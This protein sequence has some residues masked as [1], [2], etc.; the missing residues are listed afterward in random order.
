M[1]EVMLM[2]PSHLAIIPDGNRRWAKLHRKSL[3][4][5]YKAGIQR[6]SDAIAWCK[7]FN[8]RMLTMWGFS[9][10]NFNRDSREVRSLLALFESKLREALRSDEFHRNKIRVR[11]IGRV[12]SFPEKIQSGFRE[13][14]RATREYREYNLNILLGYGGQRE[15]VDAC[16]AIIRDY[17][18]GAITSVDETVFPNYLYT[19]GLPD[20]DLIIRTSGEQ[21]LS[22]LMPWQSAYS[23]LYFSEK[24]WPDFEKKDMALA[25]KEFETR[26]RRFGR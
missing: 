7:D 26:K 21:R 20:P 13:L 18:S 6:A 12:D 14:E 9:T 4:E 25:L 23:E 19:H 24:L 3:I 10:E 11:I 17:N 5:G 15:I 1:D 22:G 2:K 16:N 8:I